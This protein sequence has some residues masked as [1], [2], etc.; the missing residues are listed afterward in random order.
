MAHW[1]NSTHPGGRFASRQEGEGAALVFA[2][3][4]HRQLRISSP[5]AHPR[6]MS[7]SRR[8]RRVARSADDM[9]GDVEALERP[10]KTG[11]LD[12]SGADDDSVN[13][14]AR[15]GRVNG[16][17]AVSENKCGYAATAGARRGGADPDPCRPCRRPASTARIA[18][19]SLVI[20]YIVLKYF[21]VCPRAD[22]TH[23]A[24][25]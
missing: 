5:V 16:P 24:T 12:L 20:K 25:Q 15:V 6:R 14:E 21:V 2:M 17:T 9:D 10:G 18:K 1:P 22:R 3:A 19:D 13:F 11:V 4:G 23:V 8:S 7:V